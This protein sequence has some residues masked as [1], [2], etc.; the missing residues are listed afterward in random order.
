MGRRH[1]CKGLDLNSNSKNRLMLRTSLLIL[2]VIALS[3]PSSSHASNINAQC[4]LVIDGG[5]RLRTRCH[6]QASKDGVD[7][8]S[9]KKLIVVCPNGKSTT[10]SSCPGYLQ[11][12]TKMGAFGYL[13]RDGTS[14]M[15]QGN[16]NSA[17]ICWN[18]GWMRKAE[19]CFDGL[20]REGAC[21]K[22][23]S[24]KARHGGT[25]HNIRFCAY[26]L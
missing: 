7:Y 11:K 10:T 15:P 16:G 17:N 3:T 20:S 26:A 25:R 12:V 9:D 5:I 22:S 2:C 23:H 14:N 18:D 1:Q 8:F 24:A 4:S 13:Y 21:W 6:F 19:S